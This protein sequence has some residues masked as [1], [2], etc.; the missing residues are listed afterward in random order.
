MISAR[1]HVCNHSHTHAPTPPVVSQVQCSEEEL[2][3]YRDLVDRAV[4]ARTH[5]YTPNSHSMVGS[6]V[7]AQDGK[8]YS[9][10]NFELTPYA[11][12][13]EQLALAF[14]LADGQKPKDLKA[15]AVFVAKEGASVEEA[16][17]KQSSMTSCGNCRQAIF[18]INPEMHEILL[19]SDGYNVEVY[20]AGDMLP[21]AYH[22]DRPEVPNLAPPSSDHPDPL[23]A[24]ALIARSRSFVPRTN[25]PVGAAVETVDGKIYTGIRVETSSFSTQAERVAMAN[26]MMHGEHQIKR[27]VIVGGSSAEGE[28]PKRLSWDA[29]QAVAQQS[30]QAEVLLPDGHGGFVS[31]PIAQVP[32]YLLT[33]S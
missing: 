11:D 2:G 5:A 32:G 31:N 28:I 19:A 6:S 13:G 7:L 3:Q 14:A 1:P 12:H 18:E 25:E 16:R 26:A 29:L 33:H 24:Q 30:P 8:V 20:R 17:T 23:V 10:G 15:C 27:M 4:E 21:K 9:S 22:R